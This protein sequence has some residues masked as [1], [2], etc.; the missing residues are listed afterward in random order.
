MS[1]TR[2]G[3][4][5]FDRRTGFPFVGREEELASLVD[6]CRESPAVILV[7]GEPGIGK[8]GCSARPNTH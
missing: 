4:P 8:S 1:G 7:E 2:A 5:G 6:A 3:H